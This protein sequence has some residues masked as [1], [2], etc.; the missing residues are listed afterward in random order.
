MMVK[1]KKYRIVCLLFL[2]IITVILVCH[3]T[4]KLEPIGESDDYM[5]ATVAL[6]RHFS[7]KIT[8]DDIL[9]AQKDFPEY[10]WYFMDSW[11]KG[12]PAFFSMD[13]EN[14][15]P[16]YMGTYSF[17]C[18]PMKKV[19]KVFGLNQGYAY[20]ITNIIS[21]VCALI[22][23][24]RLKRLS[25]KRKLMLIGLLGISPV[26][27]YIHWPSAETFIFSC[28]IF[29]L[30]Y[31]YEKRYN[32]AA[33][34]FSLMASLNLAVFAYG[35]AIIIDFFYRMY[36]E[37]KIEKKHIKEIL[38]VAW[39]QRKRIFLLFLSFLPSL[40]TYVYN[41]VNFG[42][43]NLQNELGLATL[44]GYPRRVLSYLFDLNIGFV[45]YIPIIFLIYLIVTLIHMIKKQWEAFLYFFAFIGVVALYS[46]TYHMNCG[47]DGLPRY[48]LWT[49]PI[50][51]F[52]FSLYAGI[53]SRKYI[54]EAL[55]VIGFC[56]IIVTFML[57]NNRVSVLHFTCV[58]KA[59]M[60]TMPKLYNPDYTIFISRGEQIPGG[61]TPYSESVPKEIA[62]GEN[63][64]D[65]LPVFYCDSSGYVKKILTIPEFKDTLL[66]SIEG[67]DEGIEYI[68]RC[69]D[70]RSNTRKL[71][72]IN[73][74]SKYKI[75]IRQTG[76]NSRFAYTYG[77][78][79]KHNS[80]IPLSFLHTTDGKEYIDG[81]LEVSEEVYQY[82][83]YLKIAKGTYTVKVSG[84]NLVNAV[85][86]VTYGGG[87]GNLEVKIHKKTDT[88]LE[89]SFNADSNYDN[90]E[91]CL[92]NSS[93]NRVTIR[94]IEVK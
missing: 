59:V 31:L 58:A 41:Y 8:Y 28:M 16:W 55:Y 81:E 25:Y 34:F 2:F 53:D 77:D 92:Y 89:Y 70:S 10:S 85:P 26:W 15:Y 76:L 44:V 73:I 24:L 57:T 32:L 22:K 9:Q 67:D 83:P 84:E 52:Y 80:K 65:Y 1:E 78:T 11:E 20:A 66:S 62:L 4:Y 6:E 5:I 19:L 68:R 23:V 56:S 79:I 64:E 18:I 50:I 75:S 36:S 21:V 49:M 14:K 93:K 7:L 82:G 40:F 72:Y 91:I 71:Y 12:M 90:I 87:K 51:L 35:L 13:G 43:L 39:K 3:A 30:S 47:M 42:T 60:S 63:Y 54:K 27:G 37:E 17:L 61:Y 88:E 46:V 33:L 69:T 38:C 45:A 94:E 74:G 86:S 48:S 29:S